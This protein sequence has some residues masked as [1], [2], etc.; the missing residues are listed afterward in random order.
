MTTATDWQARLAPEAAAARGLPNAAYS[1]PGLFALERQ[2]IL[3]RHW[4]AVGHAADAPAPG[5]VVPL[6]AAGAPLLLVRGRDGVLRV[7]HNVCSHRGLTLVEAPCGGRPTIVC[8]YHGWAYD[9]TGR[10]RAT[11]DFGGHGRRQ[12]EGFVPED[13][14]LRQVRS[15]EALGGLVF[16]DLSGEAPPFTDWAAPLLARWA[17]YRFESLQR[18]QRADCV[19]EANWKLAAENFVDTLHLDWVHPQ[20]VGYSRP[21][22]HFDVIADP[23]FG[24][25]SLRAL[26]PDPLAQALPRFPGLPA[27][28]AERGEFLFLYPNLL[29]FLMPNHLFSV[30]LEAEAPDRTRE[31]FDLA[32]VSDGG[33]PP[34]EAVRWWAEGWR[35]LNDQDLD[36]LRRLQRGRASPGF[37][38]GCFSGVMDRVAHALQRRIAADLA[39]PE[40]TEP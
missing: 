14:G 4:I 37:D 23:V 15:A 33:P 21:E 3:R 8:P 38:G 30:I 25:G 32:V 31:R 2:R 24:T 18:V 35:R 20:V 28:L 10:L 36:M 39:E 27:A 22:D 40:R 19:V 7:F 9:L 17:P 5:D 1:D 13:H 26:S 12:A 6:E 16:V 34:A 11:P 29:L